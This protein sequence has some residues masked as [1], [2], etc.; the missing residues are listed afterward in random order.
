[1]LNEFLQFWIY[2]F[3]SGINYKPYLPSSPVSQ[4]KFQSWKLCK[5]ERETVPLYFR[6]WH[7]TLKILM[8]VNMCR[9]M[10]VYRNGITHLKM[11]VEAKKNLNQYTP[12]NPILN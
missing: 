12:P 5:R 1:M 3:N 2:F 11:A 7:I 8:S 9:K 10:T 6:S 4:L